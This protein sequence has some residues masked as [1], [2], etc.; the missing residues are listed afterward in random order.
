MPAFPWAR[1]VIPDFHGQRTGHADVDQ[2]TI[3]FLNRDGQCRS[4][5]DRL[6]HEGQEGITD[7]DY[8]D[9]HARRSICVVRPAALADVLA[10]AAPRKFA[11]VFIV[12]AAPGGGLR[13]GGTIGRVI[14]TGLKIARPASLFHHG[15]AGRWISFFRTTTVREPVLDTRQKSLKTS[16]QHE[17]RRHR[18]RCNCSKI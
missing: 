1:P 11:T 2:V 13:G 7:A 8:L 6:H 10:D 4:Y 3:P 12:P 18:M 9:G 15:C 5:G 14:R 17:N 16:G